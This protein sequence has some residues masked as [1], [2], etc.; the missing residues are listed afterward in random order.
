MILAMAICRS[1]RGIQSSKRLSRG[2]N[3]HHAGLA[4][5]LISI[6]S[7]PFLLTS[8]LSP[9]A[10]VDLEEVDLIW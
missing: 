4:G 7:G 6:L 1:I 5:F 2:K 9:L 10:R 8:M 3:K